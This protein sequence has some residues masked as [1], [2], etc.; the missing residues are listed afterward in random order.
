MV[1]WIMKKIP[2]LLENLEVYC[3]VYMCLLLDHILTKTNSFHSFIPH[4]FEVH[5]NIIPPSTCSAY[6][7]REFTM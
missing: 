1:T 5:H 2:Q 6:N 7:Y 3:C 4:F